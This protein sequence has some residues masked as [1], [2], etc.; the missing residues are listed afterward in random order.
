VFLYV[1]HDNAD[2]VVCPLMERGS[3]GSRDYTTPIGF[4][5]FAATTKSLPHS[6][7]ARW[8]ASL[9]E[10]E[11]VCVYLA[12]HPLYAPAWPGADES[13]AG[14]LFLLE[15]DRP[16]EKWLQ[17]VHENRRRSILAWER[18]GSPWVRD[19][20]QLTAFLLEHHAGFMRS[21]GANAASFFNDA[22]LRLLCSDPQVELVGAADTRGVCTVAGFGSTS[23]GCELL[24]HISARDGRTH[25]AALMWWAVKHYHG[26]VPVLNLGGTPRENDAL[27]AAKR[28]YRPRELPFRR[29]KHVVD[30]RKYGELCA[31]AG[32]PADD[33]SGYFPAYRRNDQPS[34]DAYEPH[35][36][37]AAA[38]NQ[39]L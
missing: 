31:Q 18:G 30:R 38:S 27:A 37:V 3:S 4:S 10:K 7:P 20:E 24:F 12:Q 22:A 36:Q 33:F 2:R 21:V 26:K 19:R 23:W 28:R 39:R 9:R 15:L 14:S 1:A 16:P 17:G 25:T 35:S 5:G 6:F 11:A 13:A 29:L 34:S 8:S 32:V